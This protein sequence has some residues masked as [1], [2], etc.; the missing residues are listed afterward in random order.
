MTLPSTDLGL[1]QL[2]TMTPMGLYS[3]AGDFWIDPWGPTK[4]A[5]ITHAHSD[6]A[7]PGSTSYLCAKRGE[8]ILAAR[9]GHNSPIET[10]PWGE[11]VSLN[12]V[13]VSLHPA[14][15]ILGSA[16]VRIEYKGH[17]C[18]ITGDYKVQPD[19][20]CDPF[21]PVPCHT[22]ISESTFGL[23]V[24]YW[25]NEKRMYEDILDWWRDNAS[26]GITSVLLAYALGKAQRILH[27]LVERPLPG[28]IGVHGSLEKFLP[29]YEAQG[30]T[31]PPVERALVSNAPKLRGTG[32]LMAPPSVQGSTYL[33]KF[34]PV[35]LAMASGW[36]MI[37][38]IRRRRALDRGFVLSDHADWPGLLTAI[39]AT[40]A[41]RVGLTHG[42]TQPLANYLHQ[43]GSHETFLLETQFT[44][45]TS[46]LQRNDK[47]NDSPSE[48]S[49]CPPS[50][51]EET[52]DAEFPE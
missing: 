42:Y 25:P 6:H 26:R 15:H 46:D 50:E 32:L 22:L 35:S 23:P 34:Q 39:E 21:E 19:P 14:G 5:I 7:R 27:R 20:T 47:S 51:L 31:M 43:R 13:K 45:E 18:V 48:Q 52:P 2:L 37:K 16:Q 24:Y 17:I 4:R 12:N 28:P 44:G 10:L 9:I 38:G 29:L 41:T 3:P 33:R 1:G 11:T 36:M 40:G 49:P 30:I 8:K